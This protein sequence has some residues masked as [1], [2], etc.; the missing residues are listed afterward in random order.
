MAVGN[1]VKIPCNSS[2]GWKCKLSGSSTRATP[3]RLGFVSSVSSKAWLRQRVSALRRRVGHDVGSVRP[4]KVGRMGQCCSKMMVFFIFV[5]VVVIVAIFFF[6]A[7]LFPNGVGPTSRRNL[8]VFQKVS[9]AVSGSSKG[10][11][12]VDD[13]PLRCGRRRNRI[14]LC[15][16]DRMGSSGRSCRRE[17]PSVNDVGTLELEAVLPKHCQVM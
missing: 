15:R 13:T 6:V 2:R 8:D 1:I 14:I 12:R 4:S 9:G 5:V 3:A 17:I 10:H 11:G 16:V 7:K